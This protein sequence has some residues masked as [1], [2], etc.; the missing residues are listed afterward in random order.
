MT[1]AP[2]TADLRALIAPHLGRE[3]PMLPILHAVQEAHGHVPQAAVPV[4]AEALNL[5][6]AEVHG[7]VSFYHDF[8]DSPAGRHMLKICR[9]EAC[10]AM[11]GAALSEAVLEKLGLAW[12]G[13]T[14]DGAL[15]VEPVYCLG[16]CACA[17]AVMLDGR[18]H[19]RVDAARLDALLAEAR[20]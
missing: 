19:G 12:G 20:A 10:Q 8:R 14:P 15:T 2:D 4:I 18:V 11:G 3:G 13:T 7:V 6:R 1:H 17:P 5:T 16:L 9:A